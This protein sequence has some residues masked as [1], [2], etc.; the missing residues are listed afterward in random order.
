LILGT[1][2]LLDQF[3]ISIAAS[4]SFKKFY[5]RFSL[6]DRQIYPTQDVTAIFRK[7]KTKESLEYTCLSEQ[8]CIFDWLKCNGIVKGNIVEFSEKPI[9]SIPF[10]PINWNKKE[11]VALHDEITKL[12]LHYVD[13]KENAI[14]PKINYSVNKLINI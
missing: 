4:N 11:E 1:L 2:K 10:R 13:T 7:E 5:F 8:S 6:V 12:T 3:S 14:L 9:S